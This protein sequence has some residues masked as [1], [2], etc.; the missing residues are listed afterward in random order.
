MMEDKQYGF[1]QV[2]FQS[3]SASYRPF[4]HTL[5]FLSEKYLFSV[6]LPRVDATL[7]AYA[8]IAVFD[9]GYNIGRNSKTE[10]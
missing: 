1:R 4:A 6:E 9:L 8:V 3:C 5:K 10:E 7:D 2:E